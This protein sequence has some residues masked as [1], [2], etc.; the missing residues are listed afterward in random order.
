MKR[1]DS[2]G[3]S[4]PELL[5]TIVV[6]GVVLVITGSLFGTGI[7]VFS[8]ETTAVT[9]QNDLAAAKSILLDDL[10]IAGFQVAGGTNPFL[11]VNTAGALDSI[12]FLG[13]SNSDFEDATPGVIEKIC[14]DV[15]GGVLRR[16]E[17]PS[18]GACG[19]G[20]NGWQ[21]LASDVIEF[22]LFLFNSV[23]AP[24]TD[25]N[26]MLA[27]LQCW[28]TPPATAKRPDSERQR[29]LLRVRLTSRDLN[30]RQQVVQKQLT[31]EAAIRN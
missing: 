16:S 21:A 10:S 4:L 30:V 22:N 27:G 19:S 31:G 26:A 3:F 8:R 29:H 17:Q 18:T 1:L 24:I 28:P 9:Q 23:R 6:F 20:P 25:A 11:A 13:D 2:S 5:V 7:R 15:S 14:Y 12:E